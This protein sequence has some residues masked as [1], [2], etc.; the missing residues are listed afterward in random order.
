MRLR[1]RSSHTHRPT[2]ATHRHQG[3]PDG[4]R[5]RTRTVPASRRRRRR[6]GDRLL[7][8]GFWRRRN[9]PGAPPRRQA[10]PRRGAHQRLP[11]DAQRR[12]P[13]DVRRQV[14]DPDVAGRNSG[15]HPSDGDRRRR[16]VPTGARRRRH[17]GH[18]ARRPVLGR[19]LR[20]GRRSVRSPLVAGSAR[21]RGQQRRDRRR[22]GQPARGRP[23][24]AAD[25]PAC[26]AAEASAR[27]PRRRAC[28][29]SR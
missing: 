11:G 29:R 21:A 18:A 4:N 23:T 6:R 12:L 19:S 26:G 16:Q 1:R 9:R 15:H 10:D 2:R 3:G 27:R 7:R 22:D 25:R 13:G 5:R 17:R 28:R 24:R 14:D 20:H 8:Q